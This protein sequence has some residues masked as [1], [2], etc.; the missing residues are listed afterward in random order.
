M[1]SKQAMAYRGPATA[2]I[3]PGARIDPTDHS[4]WKNRLKSIRNRIGSRLNRAGLE[5]K[6]F[7]VL[8]NDCWAQALYEDFGLPYQSPMI[9]CG[10]HADGFLRFLENA[11]YYLRTPITFIP[12]SRNAAV[13]RLRT[14]RRS[15]PIGLLGDEVEVHFMQYRSEEDARRTWETGCANLCFDRILVK[16]SV[17]KDGATQQ[18]IDRF[19]SMPFERKLLISAHRHPEIDY[20]IYAPDYAMNGAF[21]FRRSLKYFDCAH[22]VNTGQV[23]RITP[24]VMLN[25]L[26]YA[27]GA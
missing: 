14:N 26:L 10:M 19:V 12:D 9:G 27:R 22:W 2:A 13:R 21:M 17:D 8:S 24:K 18:H 4:Q 20:A 3:L 25:K 7:T 23:R 16:F 15:W 11:E 6:Q 1:A 5:Y